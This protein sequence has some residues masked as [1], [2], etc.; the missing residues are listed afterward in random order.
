MSDKINS[1]YKSKKIVFSKKITKPQKEL[2]IYIKEYIDNKSKIIS[3]SKVK[4]LIT[5]FKLQ[6]QIIESKNIFS[7]QRIILDLSRIDL[8]GI[9]NYYILFHFYNL[10]FKSLQK[11]KESDLIDFLYKLSFKYKSSTLNLYKTILKDFFNFLNKKED[12]NFNFKVTNMS[13]LKEKKI[14]KFLSSERY[15][16]FI[17]NLKN[18]KPKTDYQKRN[19]LILLIVSYT[20]MRSQEV[21]SLKIENI[22]ADTEFFIFKVNGKGNKERLCKIKK[23]LIE[24]P[25]KDWLNSKLRKEKHEEGFLFKSSKNTKLARYFLNSKLKEMGFLDNFK[26][27]GMHM[28]RHSFGSYVYSKTKDLILTSKTLGHESIETTKIYVHTSN[29]YFDKICELF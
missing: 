7:L 8:V 28:L 18:F 25:L 20:G 9:K 19:K 24:T 4:D 29:N 2:F 22:K 11:F 3:K 16:H 14:P 23:E 15:I 26:V 13:F 1:T 6:S 10:N 12:F 21:G 17:N 5:F 27:A